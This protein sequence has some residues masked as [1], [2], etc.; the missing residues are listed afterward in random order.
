MTG[1]TLVK[2]NLVNH[3][4]VLLDGSSSMGVHK[5]SVIKAADSLI[6]YLAKRSQELQQETRVSIWVFSGEVRW[7]YGH[8]KGDDVVQNIIWD[9]DVLRLPSVATFYEAN[10]NTALIDATM[11]GIRDLKET[12]QRHGDHSFLLHVLTDGEEN[13]SHR[14]VSQLQAELRSLPDNWTVGALV[15]DSSGARAA[16]RYGFPAG[17]I[18]EWDTRSA[19]GIEDAIRRVEQSTDTYMQNRA[20]GTRSTTSLY[21]VSSATL[22]RQSVAQ[23]GMRPADPASYLLHFIPPITSPFPKAMKYR[24]KFRIDG[25][26]KDTL[27]MAFHLTRNYYELVKSETIEPQKDIALVDKKTGEVFIGREARKVIG[28]P[29][30]KVRIRPSFNDQYYI[31]IRSD[32]TNRNL[33]EGSRLLILK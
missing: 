13:M 22:N 2:K 19:T 9:M 7:D 15:P 27:G 11:V 26:V 33:P 3:I 30:Q 8:P 12:P 10:G 14:T 5:Q 6:K 29:D 23:A 25:Y 32:S 16:L 17:N 21:D 28:L 31:L 24:Q 18:A 4:G 20:T 1:K